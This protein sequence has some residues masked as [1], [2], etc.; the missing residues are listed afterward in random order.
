MT[1]RHYHRLSVAEKERYQRE[2]IREPSI[3]C[4]VCEAQ[5]T[6]D[7]L[8]AHL[9]ERCAGRREPHHLSRWVTW[10]EALALG[11]RRGTLSKWVR[12]EAV[13]VR[14]NETQREYLLR[15][16]IRQL[17]LSRL[18]RFPSGNQGS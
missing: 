13:R 1:R 14:S 5:T 9:A 4:P 10:S 2:R 3:S 12:R 15:D 7:D 18:R 6:V 16:L 17:G 8:L 11:I